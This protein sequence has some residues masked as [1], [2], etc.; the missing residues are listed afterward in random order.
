M[1]LHLLKGLL[2]VQ[3]YRRPTSHA[4]FLGWNGRRCI[5]ANA[6][7]FV[8]KTQSPSNIKA[9]EK[10]PQQPSSCLFRVEVEVIVGDH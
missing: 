5:P 4:V 6:S 8:V 3:R 7:A 1:L 10:L 9:G 2:V